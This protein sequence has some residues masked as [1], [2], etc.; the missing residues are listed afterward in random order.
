MEHV[1][2][3]SPGV[4]VGGPGPAERQASARRRCPLQASAQQA[5]AEV[6]Q[7]LGLPLSQVSPP[8]GGQRLLPALPRAQVR[9]RALPQPPL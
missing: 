3:P 2:E 7:R 4:P 6:L 9:V 1:E 5:A 8:Q